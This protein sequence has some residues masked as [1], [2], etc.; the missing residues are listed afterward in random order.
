[1]EPA[2]RGRGAGAGVGGLEGGAKMGWKMGVGFGYGG[3]CRGVLQRGGVAGPPGRWIPAAWRAG[4]DGMGW[5][6]WAGLVGFSSR[7]LFVLLRGWFAMGVGFDGPGI[8]KEARLRS[9]M[10]K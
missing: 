6:G 5:D 2:L 8:G 10:Q 9:H 1:M 7:A 4:L 3:F